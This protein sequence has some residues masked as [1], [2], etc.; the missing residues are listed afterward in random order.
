[1]LTTESQ[2]VFLNFLG[3]LAHHPAE[4]KQHALLNSQNAWFANRLGPGMTLQNS[5]IIST[6]WLFDQYTAWK[7]RTGTANPTVYE[8]QHGEKK[9]ITLYIRYFLHPTRIMSHEF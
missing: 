7:Q 9:S 6:A 8:Y 3:W 5:C 4:L 1:M 2:T